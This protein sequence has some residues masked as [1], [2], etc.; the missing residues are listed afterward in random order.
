MKMF[1]PHLTALFSAFAITFILTPIV[2]EMNRRFGMIDKPD[3]R[4]INTTPIPRG[5]GLAIVAGTTAACA[6][7]ISVFGGGALSFF[8]A[9]WKLGVLAVLIAAT[10]YADDKF[11]LSPKLKLAAQLVIALLA[12]LWAGIGFHRIWPGINPVLDCAITTFWICGAVNAFNLIDGL[13]GLASGLALI[14]TLGMAGTLFMIQMPD[15]AVFHFVFAGALLAFLCYNYHPAS[16][17]LGDC[18]SMFIGF[19][20]SVIPLVAQTA[21]SFLVSVGVPL[22]AMGVPIFDTALAIVRRSIR[23]MIRKRAPSAGEVGNDKVMTADADH[24]HHRILRAAK[25]N[26]RRAAWIL[27]LAAAF[28]VGVGLVGVALRSKA[29]GLWLFAVAI[30]S[31][32]IFKDVARIELFDA[33]RL[34]NSIARDHA[35]GS[36]RRF[37]RLAIPFYLAFDIFALVAVFFICNWAMGFDIGLEELRVVLPLRVISVFVLLFSVGIY[38]TVWARAMS[39]NYV[40]LLL[41]CIF[42]SCLGTIAIY[43]AP[44]IE[45]AKLKAMTLLYAMTS[46]VALVVVRFA[47]GIVRDLFYAIDCS[48]LKGRKDVS[49]VLVYGCGL[50]YR[51]FRRE[52]VRTTAANDRII[53]GLLDDDLLLRGHYI[54]GLRV[55]G[56]LQQAPEIINKLNADAVV[57]ACDVRPEWMKVVRQTLEPTGVKISLFSFAEKPV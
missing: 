52:L 15:A 11:S 49:R 3:A 47:R 35:R 44:G 21:N 1:I 12:W 29:G 48:R 40:R 10:G 26:Q 14:A 23:H 25:L 28:F 30:A 57:I 2:R 24:I 42:G 27:Y 16:V 18:G 45:H 39:S 46:C 34:L 4:R 50:R 22:L 17:F 51:A 9:Q 33:G 20:L 56:T 53:V 55:M 8:G 37:A 38:R 43:Y 6:I 13:D 41:A 36:R 7:T 5:G 19:T 54:G 32:A 31:I